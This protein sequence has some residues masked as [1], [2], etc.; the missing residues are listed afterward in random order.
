VPLQHPRT[1][2]VHNVVPM[3]PYQGKPGQWIDG[4]VGGADPAGTE[5]CLYIIDKLVSGYGTDAD[6]TKLVDDDA[7]YLCPVVN[8][9][10]YSPAADGKRPAADAA[11]NGN[12]PEGWWKDDN[13]PGGTGDY[14]SSFPEARAVLEF[15]TNHTNILLVQSFDS[16]GGYTVRPFARW[17]ESRVDPR[18]IAILDGV[19]GKKY[20]ELVGQAGAAHAWRSGYNADRQAP[21]AYG[22]FTDWAYGQFG[23]YAM[24]TQ[25]TDPQGGSLDKWCDAAWQFE[26]YKAML[27]PR[28][29]IREA[30]AKLLYTTNQATKATASDPAADTVIVKKGGPAGR[31]RVIE[32]SA[33]VEN[34][35][36]LPTQ[37]ARGTELRGNRQDVIWLLGD[38][39][40][41]TFLQGSRWVAL[42]VLQGTLPLART[43]AEGGRGGRG[44]AAGGGGGG[45]GGRGGVGISPLAEMREQ[46]PT[47]AVTRQTGRSRTVSWLVAVEGDAP[48]K[49]ALTSQKGGTTV[50]DLVIQ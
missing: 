40:K 39:T 13:T 7:F 31:Y 32:V 17:P 28:V 35:G 45:R 44:A 12:F 18:D 3:K 41:M 22:A 10:A 49:L 4:G 33:T 6:I 50:K 47:P 29:Q 24:S 15:F 46:R 16:T 37:V 11:T 2:A 30:S 14:P 1:P 19:I 34:A 5:A 26:R 21:S 8:P 9:E 43:A 42:G 27:L 20:Q 23:A 36:P 38:R 48:L 25:V